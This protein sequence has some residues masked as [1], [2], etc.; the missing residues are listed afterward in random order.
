MLLS[1]A[2]RLV[3]CLLERHAAMPHGRLRH[4]IN[5]MFGAHRCASARVDSRDPVVASVLTAG[6]ART[7]ATLRGSARE[8][9]LRRDRWCCALPGGKCGGKLAAG[10]DAELGEDFAQVVGD[11]GGADEQ[12]RGDLR[13]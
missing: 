10:T 1:V 13:V 7:A 12:L 11:G 8:L 2:G 6:H 4:E 3:E 5:A 9:A